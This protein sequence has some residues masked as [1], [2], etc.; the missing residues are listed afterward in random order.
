MQW[1]PIRVTEIIAV[2]GEDKIDFGS[3]GYILIGSSGRN[4]VP[5]FGDLFVSR[6]RVI[7]SLIRWRHFA[8]NIPIDQKSKRI[9][10][11]W[12]TLVNADGCKLLK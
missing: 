8:L 2:I 6:F 11:S 5:C 9:L 12:R 10:T 3:V 7:D 1:S 4:Y